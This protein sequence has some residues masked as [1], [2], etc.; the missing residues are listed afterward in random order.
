MCGGCKKIVKSQRREF[1]EYG[2]LDLLKEQSK[3]DYNKSI[4][5]TVR[6]AFGWASNLL[7]RRIAFWT[8]Y[9][10]PHSPGMKNI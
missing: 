1:T 9:S 3:V 5:A 6:S 10:L 2:A 4:E 7:L 8:P